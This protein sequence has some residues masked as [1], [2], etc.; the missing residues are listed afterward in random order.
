M[1]SSNKYAIVLGWCILLITSLV[2]YAVS[3]SLSQVR[4]ERVTIVNG[5]FEKAVYEDKVKRLEGIRV[6]HWQID[7][8]SPSLSDSIRIETAE[9]VKSY[10]R[11]KEQTLQS[12]SEKRNMIEHFYLMMKKPIQVS[13]LDSLFQATLLDNGV[14]AQTAVCY[15]KMEDGKLTLIR[16]CQDESFYV[17]A[18]AASP[19][20]IGSNELGLKL[21]GFVKF[22][23]ISLLISTPYLWDIFSLYLFVIILIF[24]FGLWIR[25]RNSNRS[26]PTVNLALPIQEIVDDKEE[27][28]FLYQTSPKWIKITEELLLDEESGILKYKDATAQLVQLRLSLFLF[29]LK[30]PAYY[31]SYEDLKKAVWENE[32]Y[33]NVRVKKMIGRLRDDLESIKIIEIENIRNKGYQLI[34]KDNS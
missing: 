19:V 1:K 11:T 20:L 6:I 21:E 18:I 10:K 9:S 12:L 16:S 29:L 28:P 31:R 22:S 26:L 23:F 32:K 8:V 13:V 4:K 3:V 25:K 24:V 15:T 7:T 5:L 34:I 2:V 14:D 33:D 27:I 17:T 30:G